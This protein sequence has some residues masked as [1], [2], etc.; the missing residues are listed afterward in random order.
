MTPWSDRLTVSVKLFTGGITAF[1]EFAE[2]SGASCGTVGRQ[3]I[4]MQ[5]NPPI[6]PNRP[7]APQPRS[8][9]GTGI[10]GILVLVA[11]IYLVDHA[12]KGEAAVFSGVERRVS[13]LDFHSAQ[14]TAVFGGCKI[15]L[16]DAQIQGREAVVDAYA[17]FGGVEIRVPEDWEVV[18]RG[19]GIFGG[20]SDHRRRPEVGPN[21]K[22]L[23]L[24]G[25]AIFGGVDVKN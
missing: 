18:N 8:S 21:T 2:P 10:V 7:V 25:A 1:A 19:M 4:V 16:R 14:C 20:M 11:F 12:D 24:N 3:E 13:T 5:P 22:T 15:D 6:A 23:I 17:V 9:A